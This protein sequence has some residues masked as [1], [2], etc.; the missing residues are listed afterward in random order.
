MNENEHDIRDGIVTIDAKPYAIQDFALN[1]DNPKRQLR[2]T[3][4][5]GTGDDLDW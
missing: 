1:L 3:I 4:S 2:V 5:M